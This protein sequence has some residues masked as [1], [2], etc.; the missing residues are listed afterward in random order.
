MPKVLP[1]SLEVLDL[2]GSD[3]EYD[4]SLPHTFTGGIPSGWDA[5]T[6][7]KELKM[8]Y[9]SLDGKRL[10]TRSERFDLSD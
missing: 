9:C 4:R 2:S 5:L 8:A 1:A 3:G 7:L 10:R 6:N